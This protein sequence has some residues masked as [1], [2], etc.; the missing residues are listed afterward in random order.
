M[1]KKILLKFIISLSIFKI[2][3]IFAQPNI[4]AYVEGEHFT[5]KSPFKFRVSISLG[6]EKNLY[7]LSIPEVKF[8][9]E[10][11][12]KGVSS[13]SDNLTNS[14]NYLYTLIPLKEGEYTIE[15]VTV[16]YLKKGEKEPYILKSNSVKFIVIP[17]KILGFLWWQFILIVTFLLIIL[18]LIIIF[19]T[20]MKR[21]EIVSTT[22]NE[23]RKK[24]FDKLN[25]AY[26]HKLDGNIGEFYKTLYE[27]E[28]EVENKLNE[29]ILP[30]DINLMIERIKFGGYN[31][32]PED[33]E[34]V[35]RQV[36]REIKKIFPEEEGD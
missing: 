20:K 34:S 9:P 23:E 6:E 24:L 12:E 30:E 8:P 25:I 31:P 10:I 28:K 3:L 26:K 32:T 16:K 36:E 2:N 18:T 21:K 17:Y 22:P 1:K 11:Q 35:Y 14:T 4:T 27:I 29:K 5:V 19:S 13:Y 33:I 7:T 15:S